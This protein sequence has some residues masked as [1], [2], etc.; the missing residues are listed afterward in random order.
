MPLIDE[1]A[2]IPGSGF[3]HLA[4]PD[5]PKPTA[6]TDPRNPGPG[7]NNIGHTSLD[8]LPEFGRDGDKPETVG[9]WQNAK[10]R[11]TSPDVT[12]SVTFN[13]VQA[14]ADTYRL[15]FGA[16]HEAVQPDGSFRIPARPEPQVGALLF[17][18]IDGAHMV[19][20]WHPRTSLL[21]S[22]A[23]KM[24]ATKFWSFPIV[25][26][27]LGSSTIGGAIGEW[28]AVASSGPHS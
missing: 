20:L 4:D 16:G 28:A 10:L 9:T 13:S 12:Y 25:A 21:G 8:D 11:Q 15:Y 24:D 7:W 3:I 1:A 2:I 17:I 19:P 27:F 6:I 5:T 26:T 18:V 23:V 22:D 14:T